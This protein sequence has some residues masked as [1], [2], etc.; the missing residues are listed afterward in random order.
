MK[1]VISE[2][3]V[4]AESLQVLPEQYDEVSIL[5]DLFNYGPSSVEV[6]DFG[7]SKTALVVRGNHDHSVGLGKDPRCSTRFRATADSTGQ[8]T[9]WSRT[10]PA[11]R[12]MAPFCTR[13]HFMLRRS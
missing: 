10:G 5:G 6:I 8:L 3:H 11:K 12:K 9:S 2:I 4:N 1:I 13:G 7:R